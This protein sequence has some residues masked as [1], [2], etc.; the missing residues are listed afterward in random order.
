LPL[1]SIQTVFS[2]QQWQALIFGFISVMGL[3]GG[4]LR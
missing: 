1:T 3:D 4:D 2:C